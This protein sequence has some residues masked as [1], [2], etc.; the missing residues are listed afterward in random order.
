MLPA[1]ATDNKCWVQAFSVVFGVINAAEV[2]TQW[3]KIKQIPR[4]S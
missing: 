3:S 2:A 1:M 4:V